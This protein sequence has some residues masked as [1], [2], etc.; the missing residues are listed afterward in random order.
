M[1]IVIMV[2][3]IAIILS[4]LVFIHEGGHY[5]SARLF[6]V[7]VTEFMIGLPGPRIG[8]TWRGTKFGVTAVPLGG[9]ARVC[10]M[11]PGEESPYLKQAMSLAYERGT[12]YLEDFM[13]LT[14]LS[15]NDAYRAL[16]ELV[17]WGTLVGPKRKDRHNVFRTPEIPGVRQEGVPAP[18]EDLDA[19]YESERAQQYSSLP[20]WK[21][22]VIL[23]AGPVVNILFTIILLVLVFSVIGVDV[24][25]PDTGA[26]SHIA[27]GV[28]ESIQYGV[29]YLG[30]LVVAVAQLFNPST[31]STVVEGSVSLVGMAVLSKASLDAGIVSLLSF[32][33]MLSA[34]LG[35]MN[36]IPIPPLDGGRFII[37]VVQKIIRRPISLHLL[38]GLSMAGMALFIIFFL[39]M[40]NQDIQ[41][42]IFG[43]W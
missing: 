25:D 4:V 2:L 28:L 16:D 7:R 21:R 35:I 26:T 17:D 23:L 19:F 30:A 3:C 6:G 8:F 14:N 5:L 20:F 22:S 13:A 11:Q 12:I 37:E 10:G 24:T 33:A 9:Y 34:S 32:V 43:I 31:A 27:L 38:N 29:S 40:M 15:E 39:V 18:I 36:L 41:R 42:F 1:D